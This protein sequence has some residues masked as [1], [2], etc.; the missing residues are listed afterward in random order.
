MERPNRVA[1]Q[2]IL[3][4]E[5]LK[6]F[7]VKPRHAAREHRYP[8]IPPLIL[9]DVFHLRLR[10]PFLEGVRLNVVP[11][12]RTQTRDRRTKDQKDRHPGEAAAIRWLDEREGRPVIASR[13][14]RST[15]QWGSEASSLTGL[16][17]VAGWSHEAQHRG[18]ET[19]H[20]RAT[21]AD[22]IFTANASVR[23]RL[24]KE[25]D[26]RYVY[27]GPRERAKADYTAETFRWLT[28]VEA[29]EYGNVTL[30]VV[31]QSELG[32][33]EGYDPARVESAERR[34]S[35][36]EV[37]EALREEYCSRPPDERP[38]WVESLCSD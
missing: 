35:S 37:N 16:P 20:A 32:V 28:G 3:R 38:S 31:D 29:R 30:Y 5:C 27:W 22:A 17:T 9:Q 18:W 10:E 25:Y 33:K 34:T 8:K 19:W 24:L 12:R 11:L 2:P 13:P 21:D 4:R 23:V 6:L 15:Y 7:P 1:G 36:R 14:T 26:V